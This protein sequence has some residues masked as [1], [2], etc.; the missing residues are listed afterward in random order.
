MSSSNMNSEEW[1][2]LPLGSLSKYA[3]R[4]RDAKGRRRMHL[5]GY[6]VSLAASILLISFYVLSGSISTGG[7]FQPFSIDKEIAGVRCSQVKAKARDFVLDRLE[8]EVTIRI[9]NH[10]AACPSCAAWVEK[11]RGEQAN[12]SFGLS[13]ILLVVVSGSFSSR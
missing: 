10:I 9:H 8:S 13:R 11:A 4:V 7:R 6:G 2:E 5:F 12:R 3:K 1:A